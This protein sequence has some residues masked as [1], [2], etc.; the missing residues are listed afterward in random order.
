MA[1]AENGGFV[2]RD[3][4]WPDRGLRGRVGPD[5]IANPAG[6]SHTAGGTA[7][8][9]NALR[10]AVLGADDGVVSVAGI[11]L[12]VAGPTAAR[13]PIFTAGLVSLIAGAVSMSL[14]QH[15]PLSSQRDGE[16]AQLAAEN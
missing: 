13:A 12:G 9:L 1:L 4:N 5:G 7:R 16:T 3:H 15:V 6:E 2:Y 8:R 11:V 10:T 14:G